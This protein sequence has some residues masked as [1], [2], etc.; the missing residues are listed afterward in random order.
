MASSKS[1]VGG[2]LSDLRDLC[3]G[4]ELM[5]NALLQSQFPEPYHPKSI[6][7]VPEEDQADSTGLDVLIVLIR[8]IISQLP[9]AYRDLRDEAI[10]RQEGENPLLRL[11]MADFQSADKPTFQSGRLQALKTF[12]G[13]PLKAQDLSFSALVEHK[14][15]RETFWLRRP[16]LLFDLHTVV[17]DKGV[18]RQAKFDPAEV[19]KE[20]LVTFTTG[21][22]GQVIS[23]RFGSFCDGDAPSVIMQSNLPAIIRVRY[24]V[25]ASD[26]KR[27]QDLRKIR[28]DMIR[29]EQKSPGL[30]DRTEPGTAMMTYRLIAEVRLSSSPKVKDTIRTYTGWGQVI[31]IP[32][33]FPANHASE[34]LGEAGSYML[35]YAQGVDDIAGEHTCTEVS[36]PFSKLKADMLECAIRGDA[37]PSPSASQGAAEAGS[38]EV[39]AEVAE[40]EEVEEAKDV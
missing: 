9:M 33:S 37:W 35:Y 8:R 32:S 4:H 21:D 36:A 2:G 6:S 28:V 38:V 14:L 18:C 3:A 34:P 31:P 27:Y 7:G 5:Q 13:G 40:V 19:A 22:L 26:P 10:R 12:Y 24:D 1:Q 30:W 17:S 11:A 25:S 20:S 15:M 39:E 16:L 23:D 29:L